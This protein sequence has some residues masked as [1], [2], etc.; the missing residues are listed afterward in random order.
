MTQQQLEALLGRSL[1]AREIANRQLY[2]DIAREQL[3]Q[4]LCMELEVQEASTA[5][6]ETRVF[7]GREGYSTTFTGIF[8]DVQSVKVDG[9]AVTDFYPAFFDNRNAGFYNSIVFNKHVHNGHC[10][11][12]IEAL[13]GFE[14]Y[15]SDLEL[16][17][18][19]AFAGVSSTYQAKDVKSKRVEDFQI[20]YG[21]LSDNDVFVNANARTL[22]KYSMCRVGYVLHGG[23]C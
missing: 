3:E 7:T 22:S 2:L 8:T 19:R 15:P 9:E 12:E 23:R 18:A 11:V 16:L 20:T 13:W 4:L 5:T 10:E 21:N 14:D 6:P 17:L 1:T